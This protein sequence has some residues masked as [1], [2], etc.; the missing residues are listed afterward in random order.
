MKDKEQ[1]AHDIALAYL[2]RTDKLNQTST[3][4]QFFDVYEDVVKRIVEHQKQKHPV[5]WSPY[6]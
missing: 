1:I 6:L 2:H 3:P 5:D 4:E